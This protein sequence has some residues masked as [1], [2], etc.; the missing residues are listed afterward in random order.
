MIKLSKLYIQNLD[1]A[2]IEAFFV[3]GEEIPYHI[4]T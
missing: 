1:S 3:S 2:G 4:I